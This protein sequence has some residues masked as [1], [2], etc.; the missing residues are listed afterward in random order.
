MERKT[1]ASKDENRKEETGQDEKS[2]EFKDSGSPDIKVKTLEEILREKALKKLEERRAQNKDAKSEEKECKEEENL[3]EGDKDAEK[4]E[5]DVSSVGESESSEKS[6]LKK[7]VSTRNKDNSIEGSS[8]KVITERKVS[9]SEDGNN[10]DGSSDRAVRRKVSSNECRNWPLQEVIS[11]V[12]KDSNRTKTSAESA[13]IVETVSPMDNEEKKEE[14]SGEPPSPF[15]GVRVKSFE[16][17]ME[18]KRKRR[19]EKE[20]SEEASENVGKESATNALEPASNSTVLALSPPKRLKRIVKKSFGDSEKESTV[21]SS[22]SKDS[23]V[24]SV[25]P[26][27]KRTVFVMEKPSPRKKITDNGKWSFL[28]VFVFCF[29]KPFYFLNQTFVVTLYIQL[30]MYYYCMFC[31]C[32]VL[33]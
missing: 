3:D 11:T 12:S 23:A 1:S 4:A 20:G 10:V 8:K 2:D 33:Q 18:L 5:E 17:I 24:S 15:Q 9:S 30:Y 21:V 14:S 19:A 28:F 27:R 6:P 7:V 32:V 22:S 26:T 25:Q 29:L 13:G 31:K 16:E